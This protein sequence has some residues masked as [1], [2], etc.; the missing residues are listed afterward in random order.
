MSSFWKAFLAT[1]VPLAAFGIASIV[2]P[3]GV[4]FLGAVASIGFLLALVAGIVFVVR[5]QRRVAAGIFAGLAAGI[6]VLATTC[7]ASVFT[8]R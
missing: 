6:L 8:G 5:R 3:V 4:E 7:F 2:G 1:A